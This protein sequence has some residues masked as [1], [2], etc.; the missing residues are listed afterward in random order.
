MMRQ[1]VGIS[2]MIR[3]GMAEWGGAG[4]LDGGVCRRLNS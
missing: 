4:R 2:D 1:G 3:A